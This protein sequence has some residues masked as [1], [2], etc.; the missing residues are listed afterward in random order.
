MFF[1]PHVHFHANQMHFQMKRFYSSTRVETE[2]QRN[3][4][5][6]TCFEQGQSFGITFR[7]QLLSW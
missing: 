7:P 5:W 1:L 3:T 4:K 2:A 6:P